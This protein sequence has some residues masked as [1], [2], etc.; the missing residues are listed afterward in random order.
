MAKEVADQIKTFLDARP[1]DVVP[2]PVRP[3]DGSGSVTAYSSGGVNESGAANQSEIT[4]GHEGSVH[5]NT[6]GLDNQTLHDVLQT[7][8]SN[9]HGEYNAPIASLCSDEL[10]L[11]ATIPEKVVAKIKAGEYVDLHAILNPRQENQTITV[12]NREGQASVSVKHISNRQISNIEQWTN[13]MHVYGAIYIPAH[14]AEAAAFFKYLDFIRSVARQASQTAGWVKYDELFRRVR[15]RSMRSWDSPMIIQYINLLR[16]N[17]DKR[18]PTHQ[19]GSRFN[20]PFRAGQ[21]LGFFVP[22][23]F[24]IHFHKQGT[25]SGP[26]SFSHNCP[27]CSGNHPAIHCKQQQRRPAVQNPGPGV[28]LSNQKQPM[29]GQAR[30]K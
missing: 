29:Q 16:Q 17:D 2:A 10:P 28:V 22:R 14:P 19:Q 24:C 5:D 23:G 18:N 27:K 20:Q 1:V 25:C 12:N 21:N 11:G 15:E 7:V 8:L 30:K 4:G 6:D 26:C 13:A 9:E 3:R